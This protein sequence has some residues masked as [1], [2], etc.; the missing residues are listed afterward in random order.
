MTVETSSVGDEPTLERTYEAAQRQLQRAIDLVDAALDAPKTGGVGNLKESP[1]V[2]AELRQALLHLYTERNRL[3][4]QRR[5]TGER[6]TG[7]LDFS[8][9]R[10]EILDRLDRLRTPRD[11][12]NV[13]Q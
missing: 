7:D 2:F 6:G 10:A 12:D 13:S 4:E 8:A 3:D 1:K 9:A 11:A 5:K